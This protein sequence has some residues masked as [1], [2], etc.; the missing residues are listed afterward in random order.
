LRT[1]VTTIVA[2]AAAAVA[3]A[4]SRQPDFYLDVLAYPT[5]RTTASVGA[6]PVSE[7]EIVIVPQSTRPKREG[8]VRVELISVD[9][10]AYQVGDLIIYELDVENTGSVRLVLPWSPDLTLVPRTE[11]NSTTG[12]R[13][14][15]ICLEVQDRLTGSRLAWLSGQSLVGSETTLGTLQT[16]APGQRARIRVQSRL[17]AG[18]DALASIVGEQAGAVQLVAVSNLATDGLLL[19]SANHIDVNLYR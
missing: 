10:T 18:A 4:Q 12:F 5:T 11:Q 16:L 7:D 9:R 8:G 6:L 19:K 3:V 1:I 14:A 2:T 13:S 15:W 17:V